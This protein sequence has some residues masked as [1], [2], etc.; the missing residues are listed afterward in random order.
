M[1]FFI[2][3]FLLLGIFFLQGC[4]QEKPAP[5]MSTD[6]PVQ[7]QKQ[8]KPSVVQSNKTPLKKTYT[9][10]VE[11]PPHARVRVLNIKPKYHDNM[12]LDAGKYLIEVKKQGYQK[13]KKW[14]VLDKDLVLNVSL[15]ANKNPYDTKYFKYVTKIEWKNEHDLFTLK[16]DKKTDLIWAMQSAYIDYVVQKRPRKIVADAVFAKGTPWPKISATKLDT[17]IYN[18]YFRYRGR[19]FLFKY[20]NEVTLYKAG[21]RNGAGNIVARLSK[22]KVNSMVNYYRLPK[23]K[24]MLSS[25]PFRAYQKYFQVK[26]SRYKNVKFNLP[27]LCTKLKKNSFY[28]NCSVAYAYNKRTGLYDGPRIRQEKHLEA[29]DGLYF[30]LN[31]A[32]NFALVTPVRAVETE[33]DKI[34][35][36]TKITAEQKLAAVTT[37]LIKE[38]LAKK[39]QSVAK[40]ANKMASKAMH[41]VFG[42]PKVYGGKLYAA[43]NEFARNIRS[44]KR[45]KVSVAFF[46]VYKAKLH[47]VSLK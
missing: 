14:I 41:M 5:Q 31:H 43:T 33:Y 27:I 26:Y 29:K 35:F 7:E 6:T 47:L 11:A 21:T 38:S 46:R 45:T 25:N 2:E 32:K 34:I 28:S 20:K 36:N 40:I 12:K 23:E 4:I 19:N 18:G 39:K 8:V 37:L 24:E 30:A 22:L 1:R 13:Y 10:R 44:K 15:A 16:Y 3:I 42:D 17:L 9:L